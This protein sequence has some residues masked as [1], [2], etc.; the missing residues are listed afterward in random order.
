MTEA[1]AMAA[2][3]NGYL[4]ERRQLGFDVTIQ[5][6]RIEAFA[7]FADESGHIGPLTTEI[8]LGWV[9]GKARHAVPFSWARR[10]ETLR[11]FARYLAARDPNTEF[12]KTAI[13]GGAHRRLA[14]HIYSG[15]EIGELLAAARCL[16]P[17]GTARPVTYE[18]IFGLIA[19]TGLRISEA[20]HLR[21]GDLDLDQALLT[22]WKR[23]S[24]NPGMFHCI[25]AR[26]PRYGAIWK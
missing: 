26:W 6:S 1:R 25:R 4:T 24:V 17:A 8:V 20:M 7:R 12:P 19:A 14:P 18:T 16:S 13:F 9:K 11:P 15:V 5:G 23:N 10:L 2:Q 21:C 3:A 22:V